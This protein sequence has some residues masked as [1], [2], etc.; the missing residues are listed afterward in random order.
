[1]AQLRELIVNGPSRFLGVSTHNEDV[2]LNK[3]AISYSHI[4]PGDTLAYN[5]GTADNAWLN[6]YAA[7]FRAST[8]VIVTGAAAATAAPSVAYSTSP[9][10][11]SNPKDLASWRA[12]IIVSCS[13]E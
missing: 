2:V 8:S 13:L 7:T 4:I 11:I 6:I 10:F 3:G 5:L 9:I 1:M 12:L